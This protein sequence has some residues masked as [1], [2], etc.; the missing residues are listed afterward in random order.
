M[1]TPTTNDHVMPL[2]DRIK[3]LQMQQ[4]LLRGHIRSYSNR[5]YFPS[6]CNPEYVAKCRVRLRACEIDLA[7]A[8]HE[9]EQGRLAK[10]LASKRHTDEG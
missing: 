6:H 1:S 4:R 5:K 3:G 2:R 7:I 10:V 8:R 9:Y